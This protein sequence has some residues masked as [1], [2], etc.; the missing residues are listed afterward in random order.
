MIAAPGFEKTIIHVFRVILE[1]KN[2][3]N[4]CHREVPECIYA[5]RVLLLDIFMTTVESGMV[6]ALVL[7]FFYDEPGRPFAVK[8]DD[9]LYYYIT[10]LQSDVM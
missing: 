3:S 6:T 4:N 7:D 10:N 5:I 2:P 1:A 8:I 9:V